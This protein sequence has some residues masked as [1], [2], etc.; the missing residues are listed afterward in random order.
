MI[1]RKR[2]PRGVL[3]ACAVLVLVFGASNHI[4]AFRY[5]DTTNNQGQPIFTDEK[6]PNAAQD[7][8]HVRIF[9]A[10]PIV[11]PVEVPGPP[12]NDLSCAWIPD[13]SNILLIMKTG[14]SESFHKVPTQLLSTLRCVSDFV[15]F[16]DMK[17]TI[18][19]V[20]IHDS[21]ETVLVEA[22]EGNQDFDLYRRQNDC[23]VDQE[24]CNK[25]ADGSSTSAGWILDK[26]KN[27]HIAERVYDMRPD[28]DWYVTI[29]ADTYVLWPNLVQ[30]LATLDPSKKRYLGSVTMIGDFPFGH[31]GSGY[32]LSQAAMKDFVGN[33]PGIASKYDLETKDA[34]C[35][36][37][38]LGK[39][40]KDT[41]GLSVENAWPIINGEKPFT[42]PFKPDGWCHPIATMHHMNSEEISSFWE[43][44]KRFY[45]A[46]GPG[47]N[48]T[49]LLKD[50][51]KEFLEPRLE[52]KREDWDNMSA[53][54][55]YL[56]PS[57]KEYENWQLKRMASHDLSAVEKNAHKSFDDCSNMCDEVEECF[58]FR[59]QNGIC[60]YQ[61]GFLLGEPKK[62]ESDENQRWM[63]GW[64]IDKIRAWVEEHNSCSEPL[65]PKFDT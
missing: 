52:A 34:C 32:V 19:G 61:R 7:E 56:D 40:L 54:R 18:A 8:E 23:A 60:S 20:G 55:Y 10:T 36:D 3:L 35:G 9:N 31:G 17:Q 30:W 28:Y 4:G 22:M 15:V 51:Y 47:T 12:A 2:F 43:F 13:T 39:A 64:P 44:E 27:I 25:K 11:Q 48:R 5:S 33:N 58:Q 57:A 29:D 38:M 42:L 21:L 53:D 37:Y 26:Y 45:E 59:F 49:L 46:Q 1:N 6:P 41:S 14:A 16:S 62:R 65:W 24:N 63:S 50:I